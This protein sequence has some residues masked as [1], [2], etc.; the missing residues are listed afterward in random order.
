MISIDRK[1]KLGNYITGILKQMVKLD[2]SIYD[3]AL[4]LYALVETTKMDQTYRKQDVVKLECGI[5]SDKDIEVI[6]NEMDFIKHVILLDYMR[7]HGYNMSL[8]ELLN[9]NINI[10][11]QFNGYVYYKV[12]LILTVTTKGNSSITKTNCYIEN[13]LYNECDKFK[14]NGI[15]FK[16]IN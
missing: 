16:E 12:K 9:L 11:H 6:K 7:E 1:K 10:I 13:D 2:M 3:S 5:E 15:I 14:L 8:F 4:F